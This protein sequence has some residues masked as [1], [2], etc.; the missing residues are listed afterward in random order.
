MRSLL[1]CTALIL[2]LSLAFV[3]ARTARAAD[4]VGQFR[5]ELASGKA[6]EGET[7][8]LPDGS[9]QVK[10]G[11]GITITLKKSEIRNIIPLDEKARQSMKGGAPAAGAGTTPPA[12]PANP[13]TPRKTPT[14]GLAGIVRSPI[15][16]QQIDDVLSGITAEQD[17]ETAGS[18][19][20]MAPLPLDEKRLDEM[21]RLSGA[22][23]QKNLLVKDHFVMVYTSSDESAR[24]LAAR[25]EAVY[26]SNVSFMQMLKIPGHRPEHK[27]EIYYF[28]TQEELDL[29][30]RNQG[31]P[32]PPDELGHYDPEINR[33]HFFDLQTF[34]RF[35][36]E[37]DSVSG[38][39]VDWREKRRV[40]NE[41]MRKVEAFN[42]EV[43]QHETG[44]MIHFN[45]GLFPMNVFDLMIKRGASIPIWLVEGTTMLFEVPPSS[46][47]E[48]SPAAIFLAAGDRGYQGDKARR[49]RRGRGQPDEERTQ[50]VGGGIY[51]NGE[52]GTEI[53]KRARVQGPGSSRKD[54]SRP[55]A[56]G[57]LILI[58]SALYFQS[59]YTP[60]LTA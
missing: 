14:P 54:I 20:L 58:V 25:L 21:C 56:T 42:M 7:K 60:R 8:E 16:Q 36:A 57:P 11:K 59:P 18:R 23:R 51:G 49:D 28:R 52:S 4:L 15:P 2:V 55:L 10:T 1:T 46:A 53:I 30:M 39:N 13:A 6:V 9:Y 38:K 12:G 37:L 22:D 34:P 29:Y 26:R 48:V 27:L 47:G 45:F 50:A 17:A 33:A 35:K 43:I 3:A 40:T 32:L 24:E 31:S 44:H 41:T 5:F 19:D